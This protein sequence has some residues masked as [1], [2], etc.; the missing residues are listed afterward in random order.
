VVKRVGVQQKV[1]MSDRWLCTV[2]GVD[3]APV[4]AHPRGSF[5]RSYIHGSSCQNYKFNR[6][7][8]M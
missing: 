2:L 8:Y 4:F 3:K 5:A 6:E 7:H 1:Q